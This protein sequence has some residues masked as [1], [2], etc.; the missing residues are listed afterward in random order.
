MTTDT[1]RTLEI[2]SSPAKLLRLVGIGVLMTAVAVTVTL[3]PDVP[4]IGRVVG[5][6]FGILFF[7]LCTG[8]ALW[9]LLTASGPVVTISP[10]GI[11]DTRIAAAIIPW[12]AVTGISTWQYRGQKLM[13]LAMK[14]GIEDQLGLTLAVRWSRGANRAF[15]ADG[16][17]V[18]AAGLK[19]DYDTL[20][21][22]SQDYARAYGPQASR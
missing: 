19:I 11:R 12:R 10:E 17:C 1:S 6:Y 22:T 13:V 9:R 3:L 4:Y 15:G 16:L 8:A 14:P 18:T 20:L 7:G 5:G 21:R 2:E